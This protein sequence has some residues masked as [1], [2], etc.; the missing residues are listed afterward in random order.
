MLGFKKSA[1]GGGNGAL[2]TRA[3]CAHRDN[4]SGD[5]F[6][7]LWRYGHTDGKGVS[8]MMHLH[9]GDDDGAE[10]EITDEDDLDLEPFE[11]GSGTVLTRSSYLLITIAVALILAIVWTIAE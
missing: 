1:E 8:R 10:G 4:R 3:Q 9:R 2:A 7:H 6:R 11:P 5:H